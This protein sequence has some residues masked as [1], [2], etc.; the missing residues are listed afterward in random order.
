M[1]LSLEACE[2]WNHVNYSVAVDSCVCFMPRSFPETRKQGLLMVLSS[3]INA[4]LLP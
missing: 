1:S 4:F 3:L 2:Q